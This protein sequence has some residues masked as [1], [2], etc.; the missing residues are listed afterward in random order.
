MPSN[1]ET[2]QQIRSMPIGVLDSLH[3]SRSSI[4]LL[5]PD[6][7][8]LM[9]SKLGCGSCVVGDR[10]AMALSDGSL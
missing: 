8:A 2:R 4:G 6:W 3:A 1:S 9:V 7:E 5:W 10:A